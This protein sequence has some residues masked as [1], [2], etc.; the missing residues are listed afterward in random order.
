MKTMTCRTLGGPCELEH[1]GERADDVIK[2]QDRHLKETE[3][4]GDAT[5]RRPAMPRRAGGGTPR[6]R[7]VVPRRQAGLCRSPRRLTRFPGDQ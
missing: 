2:A 4:A 3:N 6:S 5:T 7:W 1:W